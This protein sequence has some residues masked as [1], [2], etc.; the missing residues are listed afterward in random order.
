M[1]TYTFQD[2]QTKETWDEICSWDTR[3]KFLQDNPHLT[4][5]ITKAPAMV[6]SRY[7]SGI[8]N[9]EGWKENLSRIA[10]AHPQSA[11]AERYGKKDIKKIKTQQA[12]SKNKR[13]LRGKK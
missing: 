4:T 11:L 12:L 5:I 6:G 8:K 7:T 3:C 10:E 9:D 2:K 1:P 13:R